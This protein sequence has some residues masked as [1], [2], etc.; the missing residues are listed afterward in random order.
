MD[1]AAAFL[2]TRRYAAMQGATTEF[3]KQ[4]GITLAERYN[5]LYFAVTRIGKGM[6]SDPKFNQASEKF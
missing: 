3:E 4:E 6:T 1:T 2:E 5:Q